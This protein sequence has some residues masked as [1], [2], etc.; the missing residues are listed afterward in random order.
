VVKNLNDSSAPQL[1][2]QEEIALTWQPEDSQA[3]D[4]SEVPTTL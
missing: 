2:A 1:S 3:L 4:R